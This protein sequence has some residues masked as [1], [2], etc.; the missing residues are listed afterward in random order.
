[1]NNEFSE[2]NAYSFLVNLAYERFVG[3]KG[4]EEARNYI[5]LTMGKLGYDVAHEEFTVKTFNILKNEFHI[6]EPWKEEIEC[7]GVG[8]S[9][10][11]P[12]DGVVAPLIYLE[13]GDPLLLPKSKGNIFLFSEQPTS[14]DKLVEF[15]KYEPVG[16]ILSEGTPMRKPSQV[17]RLLEIG[18]KFKVPTVFIRFEDAVR[19]V[20]DNASKSKLTLVQEERDVKTYNIIFE[21]RGTGYFDE[22][23]LVGAHYDSIYGGQ[24]I[25]D[26]AGGVAL[27]M[28]LARS[29]CHV[30]TKRTIRFVLFSGEELGLRGSL[31]YVE[32]HEDELNKIKMMINLDLNGSAI[33]GC[34]AVVTGHSEIKTYLEVM[35]RELGVNLSVSQDVYSSDSTSFSNKGIPSVSFFRRSGVGAYGHTPDDDL[36]FAAPIGFKMVGLVAREVILRISNAE[37]FPFDK[38]IPDDIKKKIQEYFKNRGYEMR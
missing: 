21:K 12:E 31:N 7:R 28:E 16:M 10:S 18:K 30:D 29:L 17:A 23:V 11:T 5:T 22:V 20:K 14:A 13:T 8:L 33:G 19:L 38:D 9:G 34:N 4:E 35:S 15:T 26:N 36:R 27:V 24:G 25:M 3:T 6:L 2:V 32:A 1:M 37:K